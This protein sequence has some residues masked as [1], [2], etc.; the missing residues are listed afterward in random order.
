MV[1]G[2]VNLNSGGIHVTE[3]PEGSFSSQCCFLKICL[4]GFPATVSTAMTRTSSFVF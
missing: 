1:E 2:V 4:M 3:F